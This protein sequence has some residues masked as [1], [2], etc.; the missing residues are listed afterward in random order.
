MTSKQIM[1]KKKK[2]EMEGERG[3]SK[4]RR[5]RGREE[6]RREGENEGREGG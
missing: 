1:T 3:Q 4:E 6:I 2:E 5:E